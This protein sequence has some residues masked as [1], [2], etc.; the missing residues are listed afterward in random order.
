MTTLKRLEFL[1]IVLLALAPVMAFADGRDEKLTN[2]KPDRT[3][4]QR[5]GTLFASG[6]SVAVVVSISNYIGDRA[7]GYP[8]LRTAK[9]DAEKMVQFLLNDVGFDTIYIITEER[10][11]KARIDRLMTDEIPFLLGPNDRFL[12][13]WS[14]H[15]DQMVAADKSRSFG[16]LPLANSKVKQFSTMIDMGE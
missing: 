15:G 2:P 10:A 16:F 9:A 6:K 5:V 12:F 11:T 3:W 4:A 14:G 8:P 13:Y 1:V 7:G